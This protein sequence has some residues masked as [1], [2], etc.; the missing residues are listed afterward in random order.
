MVAF[1]DEAELLAK[2]LAGSKGLT[3][4][5]LRKFY[6]EFKLIERQ[7]EKNKFDEQGSFKK[8]EPRL[9]M[10]LPKLQY[11]SNRKDSRIP[12]LFVNEISKRIKNIKDPKAFIEFGLFFQ[13]LVGFSKTDK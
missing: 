6:Q 8:I 3:T 1:I 7:F 9:K 10:M 2:E 12:K 13:A 11:D 4:S 5:K